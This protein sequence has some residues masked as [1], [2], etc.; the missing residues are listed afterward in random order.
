MSG[1]YTF[2]TKHFRILSFLQRSTDVPI[3]DN[4]QKLLANTSAHF[5]RK[6]D[7]NTKYMPSSLSYSLFLPISLFQPTQLL[8]PCPPHVFW[9]LGA[10]AFCTHQPRG[11]KRACTL[12]KPTLLYIQQPP[13]ALIQNKYHSSFGP[14]R[15][16]PRCLQSFPMR[17]VLQ[18]SKQSKRKAGNSLT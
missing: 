4:S 15:S 6:T 12:Q 16:L 9:S 17:T 13:R 11:L 2:S 10:G 7:T 5:K 8:L 14:R 18:I 3:S 1:S